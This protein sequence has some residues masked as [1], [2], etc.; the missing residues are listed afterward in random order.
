MGTCWL[1]LHKALK[2]DSDWFSPNVAMGCGK[3]VEEAVIMPQML[4][5][6]MVLAVKLA[7]FHL[8]FSALEI[9]EEQGATRYF[10]VFRTQTQP[11]TAAVKSSNS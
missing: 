8:L 6:S 11:I 5:I 4:P 10:I 9:L 3:S 7:L 2:C 1:C